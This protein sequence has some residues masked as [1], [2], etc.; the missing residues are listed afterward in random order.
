M[1]FLRSKWRTV[2]LIL[3]LG[4][5]ASSFWFTSELVSNLAKEERKKIK[6]W[7]DA[8]K[9]LQEVPLTGD[10]PLYLYE[11]IQEN[12][13]IPRILTDEQGNIITSMNLD[14]KRE[15]D[16]VYLKKQIQIMKKAHKPIVIVLSDKSKNY[17][18]YDDSILL[19]QLSYYPL[20]QFAIIFLFLVVV[21]IALSISETSE[22]NRLWVG[23]S[24]ET[25]HQLG[26]PISS[27]LAFVEMLKMRNSNDEIA[28]EAEK[29][30]MRLEK[31]T[32]RF[33]RI[34]SEPV[35]TES[36]ITKVIV[37]LVEYLKT[38]TS[39]NIVYEQDFDPEKAIYAPVNVALF[40][41]V[42]E[43]LWKNALDAMNNMGE[44]SISIKDNHQW[45]YIDITDTG[46]GIPKRKFQ[47]IFKPGYTTKARGWGLGLS[48]AKRIV[49]IYHKGKIYVR[50]SEPGRGST[51]RIVLRK[52]NQN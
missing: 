6:I 8:S 42:I 38:R 21:Y 19:K 10:V 18:Y 44:M 37:R 24:K 31:I 1:G 15:N 45:V 52:S 12:Q 4:I 36:N 26:T 34:G 14:P 30:V 7:A 22:Q 25:A 46:K 48:L 16:S 50:Y 49:E 35:L 51:F 3:A 32:E 27:L 41:W 47:S 43:N 5:A 11:I 23:M 20:I 39:P 2:L 17:I 29:D 9:E 40:E 33:S 28:R 13:S